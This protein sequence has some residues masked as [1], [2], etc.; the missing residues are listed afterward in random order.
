MQLKELTLLLHE[1]LGNRLRVLAS[2]YHLAE[3]GIK[4]KVIWLLN[5]ELN[6]PFEK[7]FVSIPGF[8]IYNTSKRPKLF[9]S[10]QRNPFK[11]M[12]ANICNYINGYDYV[13]IGGFNNKDS[14]NRELIHNTFDKHEKVFLETLSILY[15]NQNYSIFKPVQEIADRIT[16]NYVHAQPFIGIHIRRGDNIKSQLKSGIIPFIEKTKMLLKDNPGQKFFLATDS[17]DVKELFIYLFGSAIITTDSEYS[18]NNETGIKDAL[19]ELFM[20]SKS[21]KILGSYWSSF[22]EIAARIGNTPIEKILNQQI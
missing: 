17:I 7:L 22:D 12:V 18:R 10:N 8:T 14:C 19:Y 1:G 21:Q 16:D 6:C 11:K 20:L 3:K 2:I 5:N 15:D 4:I 9:N 13:I